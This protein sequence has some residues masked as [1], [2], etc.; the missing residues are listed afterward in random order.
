MGLV[1]RNISQGLHFHC[2]GWDDIPTQAGCAEAMPT[3]KVWATEDDIAASPHRYEVGDEVEVALDG[4]STSYPYDQGWGE[5]TIVNVHPHVSEFPTSA[6]EGIDVSRLAGTVPYMV[7]LKKGETLKACPVDDPDFIRAKG[8]KY[9]TGAPTRFKVGDPVAC[10]IGPGP[11][12]WIPGTVRALWQPYPGYGRGWRQLGMFGWEPD[13]RQTPDCCPYHVTPEGEAF[14][15]KVVGKTNLMC[16][17]DNDGYVRTS[18]PTSAAFRDKAAT[19]A[20]NAADAAG[21]RGAEHHDAVIGAYKESISADPSATAALDRFIALLQKT[22]ELAVAGLGSMP[23][24][25]LRRAIRGRNPRKMPR[26]GDAK[27]ARTMLL[28]LLIEECKR[29]AEAEGRF[30]ELL[31]SLGPDR[32]V[33][34]FTMGGGFM[35]GGDDD[36]RDQ[37]P[38]VEPRF[39]VGDRVECYIARGPDGWAPGT[40]V[41]HWFRAPGWPPGKYA[42]YQIKLDDSENLIFAP[43]DRDNCIRLVGSGADAR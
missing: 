5:G 2:L 25:K 13:P 36:G 3:T 40:V 42:P 15:G 7:R 19:D 23:E 21:K 43:K 20:I 31:E 32:N 18:A 16:P 29:D 12:E 26:K 11:D 17:A 39:S 6:F 10:K 30:H 22:V 35:G 34:G 14:D 33:G 38:D 4:R 1:V 24:K 41:S 27:G 28:K 37:P 9:Q 8:A